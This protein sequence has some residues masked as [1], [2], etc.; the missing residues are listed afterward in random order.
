MKKNTDLQ[1]VLRGRAEPRIDGP[2]KVAGEALYTSDHFVP[3]LVF[4]VPARATIAKG[5]VTSIKT[6]AAQKIPGVLK[7]YSHGKLPGVFRPGA[8]EKLVSHTDEARPPFED[9]IIR[10]YGQY[11]AAVVAETLEAAEAGALALQITYENEKP[12]LEK[13]MEQ[14]TSKKIESERGD[15]RAAFAQAEVKV[16]QTYLTPVEV[17]NPIELHASVAV[18]EDNDHLTLYEASQA[19]LNHQT[20]IS[21]MLGLPKENVRVVS[22]FL[23]SGFGGKLW[24]WSHSIMTA[25]IARDLGRP[26]KLVVTRQMMFSNVGHRPRTQQRVQLG[27]DRKGKLL[28]L[29]H[30]YVSQTSILED[31]KE[32]C[33]EAT[34]YLY[35]TANLKVTSGLARRNQ[36]PPTSMR[37]PGAVPG[38]YALESAMDELAI[39][40]KIDPVELRL[41]NEPQ[42]DESN[43]LPFSSRHLKECF[44]VGARKFGWQK[45]NPL[46]GSMKKGEEILGWGVA[47]CSWGARRLACQAV[48]EIRQD[49]KVRVSSAT[50]DIG[51]GTYTVLAQIVNEQ[52]GVGFENILVSLGDTIL[53]PGPIS[54]GSMATASV[55]PAVIEAAEKAKKNLFK[56]ASETPSSPLKGEK[57]ENLKFE[58]GKVIS[59]K[60]HFSFSEVL[61]KANVNAA[62]GKGQS[63]AMMGGEKAKFSFHSFGAQFVEIGWN[64]EMARLKV[65]RV[66][67]VIDAGRIINPL[68]ARN[69]I[70]GAVVMGIGMGLFEE[71]LFDERTGQAVND[72]LADYL[73]S[74][75]A[76]CPD[77]DVTFLN[78]PDKELNEYGARG[79][80]EIGLAGVAPALTAAVYHATGV[81]VR[82]LPVRIE[83]LLKT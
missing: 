60:G 14:E 78:Y 19:I 28:S 22:R 69:Q 37:G 36:S 71:A 72:N 67:T 56:I 61:Q 29:Q 15:A 57:A 3:G 48:V 13:K 38:L 50:Q 11:V 77:I 5:K 54:G 16:D 64:P 73:V 62:I 4:A 25:A 82:E 55:V 39:Q 12:H 76:D 32:N 18:W 27:A 8:E 43:G 23:G 45:R 26:V 40:L 80:G 34:P 79:V 66:V 2:L 52:L 41:I 51:T 83:D 70:E 30:D 65:H 47:A 58:K 7:I 6:E 63:E 59:S 74:S 68:P 42:K 20:V 75:H 44:E 24:P 10:Y 1:N 81:R 31:Y 53:P 46:V 17:H 21:Q 49:G 9:N 35:S 33:G